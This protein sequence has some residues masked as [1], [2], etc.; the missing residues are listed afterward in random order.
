MNSLIR[1]LVFSARYPTHVYETTAY[2]TA[3]LL[4][5][6]LAFLASYVASPA[7]VAPFLLAS[8]AVSIGGANAAQTVRSGAARRQEKR[9]REGASDVSLP[10]DADLRRAAT[11]GS[12]LASLA[13]FLA[14]GQTFALHTLGSLR[15]WALAAA[16]LSVLVSAFDVAWSL[17]IYPAWRR[18]YTRERDR[19]RLIAANECARGT[20][21]QYQFEAKG[22]DDVRH[23]MQKLAVAL[24]SLETPP[25]EDD[26]EDAPTTFYSRSPVRVNE[27]ASIDDEPTD[28]DNKGEGF[29]Y[30]RCES[31]DD[32]LSRTTEPAPVGTRLYL[33]DDGPVVEYGGTEE[34]WFVDWLDGTTTVGIRGL[35]GG[36]VRE[37]FLDMVEGSAT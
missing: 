35:Y 33:N 2:M 3:R 25:D 7:H 36:P 6:A 24:R 28:T 20:R 4:L 14:F 30:V 1:F 31:L 12:A 27:D 8:F 9:E 29:A 26:R 17:W 16:L 32:L 10:C 18:T 15:G 19:L 23:A 34:G 11:V 21:L 5:G 13:P 37:R 22:A